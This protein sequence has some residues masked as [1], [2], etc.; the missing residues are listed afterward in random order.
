MILDI[1]MNCARMF[2]TTWQSE[3]IIQTEEFASEVIFSTQVQKLIS[4]FWIQVAVSTYVYEPCKVALFEIVQN[5]C[6]I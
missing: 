5:A 2:I 4:V 3:Q 1:H 6:F